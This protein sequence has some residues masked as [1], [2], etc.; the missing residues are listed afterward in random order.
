LG[1]GLSL[2]GEDREVASDEPILNFLLSNGEVLLAGCWPGQRPGSS[3]FNGLH[4]IVRQAPFTQAKLVDVDVDIDFAE[5][6]TPDD[7]VAVIATVPLTDNERW[8]EMQKGDLLVFENGRALGRA[9]IEA[10][11]AVVA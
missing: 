9:D 8:T 3:V 6:T 2:D 5:V 1:L 7:R 10:S 4:Y 11:G